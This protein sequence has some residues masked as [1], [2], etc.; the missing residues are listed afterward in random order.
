MRRV[1]RTRHWPWLA[2]AAA[3]AV[4]ALPA[5]VYFTGVA[6]LGDYSRGGLDAFLR[7]YL[8]DLAR[9]RPAAW[10]LLLGPVVMVAAWR[11]LL[12]LA[13]PRRRT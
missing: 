4:L 10:V 5:L 2:A 6:L 3:F 7:D 1:S 11:M 13:R 8:A 12:A 9:L